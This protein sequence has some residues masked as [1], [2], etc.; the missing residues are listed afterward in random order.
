MLTQINIQDKSYKYRLKNHHKLIVL[1]VLMLD[2][3]F[4]CYI[5]CKSFKKA[6]AS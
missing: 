3:K 1:R 4:F 2:I 5:Y 6:Q